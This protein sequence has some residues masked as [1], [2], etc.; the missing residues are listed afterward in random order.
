MKMQKSLILL[1]IAM[2]L[3][4]SLFAQEARLVAEQAAVTEGKRLEIGS[5]MYAPQYARAISQLQ[6]NSLVNE[7]AVFMWKAT[8]SNVSFPP[9]ALPRTCSPPKTSTTTSRC[10]N[11]T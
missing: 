10:A 11:T 6:W 4:G 2:L 8:R 9:R 7:P 1:G 3:G 5:L